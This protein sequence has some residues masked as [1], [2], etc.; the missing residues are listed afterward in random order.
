MLHGLNN[1]AG[2]HINIEFILFQDF[3]GPCL[4]KI[5]QTAGAFSTAY[6]NLRERAHLN[7]WYISAHVT[8]S[9]QHFS[10]AYTASQ[11]GWK[12]GCRTGK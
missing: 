4:F 1:T 10:A 9:I 5:G 8:A 2:L 3:L 12:C 6:H 7:V 11:P